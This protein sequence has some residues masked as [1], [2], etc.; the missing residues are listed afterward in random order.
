[1][2]TQ[3]IVLKKE[4]DFNWGPDKKNYYAVRCGNSLKGL[5]DWIDW[6]REYYNKPKDKFIIVDRI[7]VINS[8]EY[9]KLRHKN[10]F[11]DRFVVYSNY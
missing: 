10:G 6:A 4:Q 7:K 8:N 2:E 11:E 5:K 1:M 9:W 3:I